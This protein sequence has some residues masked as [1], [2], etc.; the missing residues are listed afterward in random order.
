MHLCELPDDILC[1]VLQQCR[2][3]HWNAK[4]NLKHDIWLLAV[5][6]RWR[7]LAIPLVFSVVFV[8]YGTT[9]A[10]GPHHGPLAAE[11]EA[12]VIMTNLDLVAAAGC[13]AVVR[14]VTVDVI[15]K[16]NPFPG[17][18]ALL[19]KL[20]TL[21]GEWSH[22]RHLFLG[23][24]PGARARNDG[25]VSPADH[26]TDLREMVDAL[27]ALFPAV[28]KLQTGGAENIPFLRELFGSLAGV[29]AD[30]LQELVTDHITLPHGRW[31]AQLKRAVLYNDCEHDFELPRMNPDTIEELE[32]L[33]FHPNHVWSSFAPSDGSQT[34]EFPRLRHLRMDYSSLLLRADQRTWVLRFPALQKLRIGSPDAEWP[35]LQHVVLPPRMATIDVSAA[36]A[37]CQNIV[38]RESQC[39]N[40]LVVRVS[41]SHMD[42][43][44]S[45]ATAN[46][47]LQMAHQ[48][49]ARV[50]VMKN[51]LTPLRPEHIS[52]TT[53]TALEVTGPMGVDSMLGLIGKLPQLTSL[54]LRNLQLDDIQ[55]DISIPASG[56]H[57][58]EA[59]LHT[60]LRAVS[61]QITQH[62]SPEPAAAVVKY[63]LLRTPTLA[64]LHTWNVPVRQV[65]DF[66]AEYSAWHPHLALASLNMY[67]PQSLDY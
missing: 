54:L 52:C 36:P 5:C 12:D 37:L 14:K 23:M 63:L 57:V 20:R 51:K 49:L 16:A 65:R 26:E 47:A 11:P 22:V 21:A 24:H 35:M 64:R 6:R 44:A 30:Q 19:E 33:R 17:L 2:Y 62:P 15:Y 25:H 60:K 31:F 67:E 29:Y 7:Q 53:L 38:A 42:D 43:P 27:A 41:R 48:C 8:A 58:L 40:R 10:I 3:D 55:S 46:N 59:P 61:I 18:R 39:A 34:I 32:L 13:A 45:L 1:A 4:T 66:V 28:R 50:L 56:T 9:V